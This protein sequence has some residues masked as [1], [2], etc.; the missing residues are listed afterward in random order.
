M[1]NKATSKEAGPIPVKP[2]Q[3]SEDLLR[4]LVESIRDYAI[5]VLDPEG[6]ILSWNS[7]A[8]R[9]KGYQ[10][11]E[12]IGQHFSRFYPKEDLE[13]GKPEMELRVATA[14]GR[15]EDEGWR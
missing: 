12:I 3:Q 8:Q 13:R 9:L 10:A 6:R 5:I 1:K 11:D 2:I 7:A 4:C 15:F 14:E